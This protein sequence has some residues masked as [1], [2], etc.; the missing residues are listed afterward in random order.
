MLIVATRYWDFNRDSSLPEVVREANL[1]ITVPG[2]SKG[3]KKT[4]PLERNPFYSYKFTSEYAWNIM[5]NEL[6][7]GEWNVR[8]MPAFHLFTANVLVTKDD[9]WVQESKR[10]PDDNGVS[11]PEV[12]NAQ[13]QTV[14]DDYKERAYSMLTSVFDFAEFTTQGMPLRFTGRT[15]R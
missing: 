9:K 14:G 12:A 15:R 13:M 1:N 6:G 8:R 2:E 11:Q 3:E 7:W 5:T 10:C 4:I